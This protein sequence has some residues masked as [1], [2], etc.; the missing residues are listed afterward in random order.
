MEF[1]GECKVTLAAYN[2]VESVKTILAGLH[3]NSDDSSTCSENEEESNSSETEGVIDLNESGGLAENSGGYVNHQHDIL[4]SASNGS[5]IDTMCDAV[6]EEQD[7]TTS[8]S[9]PM[10]IQNTDNGSHSQILPKFPTPVEIRY[11]LEDEPFGSDMLRFD[12]SFTTTDESPRI[13][14]DGYVQY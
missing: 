14:C 4:K 8:D 10:E 2:S 6:T 12:S 3:Y 11:D 1:D 13:P 7:I 5:P 9:L